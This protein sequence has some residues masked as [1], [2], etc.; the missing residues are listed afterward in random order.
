MSFSSNISLLI[1]R[2]YLTDPV[3]I[4]QLK[5]EN[6]DHRNRI[7]QLE[8]LLEEEMN[9]RKADNEAFASTIEAEM[10]ERI[11]SDDRINMAMLE[12]RENINVNL[13]GLRDDMLRENEMMR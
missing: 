12:D 7:E 3:E 6:R 8:A 2:R 1:F 13:S 10:Q 4:D 11:F 5:Q 9:Q